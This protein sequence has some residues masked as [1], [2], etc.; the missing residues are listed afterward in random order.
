MFD[1]SFSDELIN[2]PQMMMSNNKIGEIYSNDSSKK[3]IQF[4]NKG[5]ILIM[6]G[7]YDGKIVINLIE[8]KRQ[9]ELIP[10]NDDCPILSLHVSQD[11]DYLIVGNSI[12]NVAVYKIELD[13]NKWEQ[14]QILADQKTPI[15]HVYCNSDLNLFVSTT[16]DGYVN[17][18]TLPLC[19]LSRTI[20]VSTQKCSYS[21]L[22]SSPLPCIIIIN[23]EANSEIKVYSINGKEIYKHQLYYHLNNPLII[24]DLNSYE[25]LG[26]IGKDSIIIHNLPTLD[27]LVNIDISPKLGIHTIFA[28]EDK[29][30]LYCINKNGSS[31]HIIRD[32]VKKKYKNIFNNDKFINK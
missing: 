23:D 26:Y 14:I 17:L 9:V 18:Y 19:K 32:E 25:Y 20:K 16:I 30:S 29:K 8:E 4:F 22:I 10:F 3:V 6:G 5:K 27:T 21:F 24:K 1:K 15:S 2:M 31:I 13:V 7:F 11:E 28:S 12:G